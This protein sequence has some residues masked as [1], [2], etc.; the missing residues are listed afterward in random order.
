MLNAKLKIAVFKHITLN[1]LMIGEAGPYGRITNYL[2]ISKPI[3]VEFEPN[4]GGELLKEQ[5]EKL[6]KLAEQSVKEAQQKLDDLN[7]G[8]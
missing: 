2:Q 4:D 5:K 8:E 6:I 1:Y 3:E 7:N